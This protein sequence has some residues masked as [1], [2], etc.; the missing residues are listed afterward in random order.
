MEMGQE[1]GEAEA[2]ERDPERDRVIRESSREAR[3]ARNA[4]ARTVDYTLN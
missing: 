4:V 3:E 1:R 2:G